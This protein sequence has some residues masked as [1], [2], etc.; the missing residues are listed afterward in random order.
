MYAIV[1]DDL[2]PAK[3]VVESCIKVNLVLVDVFKQFVGAEHLGN[4]H[5]LT[6][7]VTHIN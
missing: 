6:A 5:Q 2:L 3:D 1:T 7:T 4:A